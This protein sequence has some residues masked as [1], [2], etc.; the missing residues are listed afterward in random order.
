MVSVLLG[1]EK[2]FGMFPRTKSVELDLTEEEA[3]YLIDKAKELYTDCSF[4]ADEGVDITISIHKHILADVNDTGTRASI[5]YVHGEPRK[6]VV[7][8]DYGVITDIYEEGSRPYKGYMPS[9]P[10]VGLKDI[11]YKIKKL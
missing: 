7:R 8:F 6:F 11:E 10:T 3:K 4:N 9:E 1:D 5:R 2:V